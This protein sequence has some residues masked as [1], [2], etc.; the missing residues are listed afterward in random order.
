[1]RAVAVLGPARFCDPTTGRMGNLRAPRLSGSRARGEHAAVKDGLV[2][3]R[4][5]VVGKVLP[6][7]G[8]IAPKPGHR[9][10]A[11]P[12]RWRRDIL[13]FS[14]HVEGKTDCEA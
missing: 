13:R 6:R 14:G 1:M 7:V 12:R 10:E 2:Q 3:A 4:P 11:S 8:P 5:L 9:L